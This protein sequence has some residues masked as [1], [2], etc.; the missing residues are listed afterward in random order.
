MANLLKRLAEAMD[1]R[2]IGYMIIG[3]QAVLVYGEPR[4]TRDVDITLATTPEDL[5]S[6]LEIVESLGLRLLVD[7]PKAFV[8]DTWVL[9][10]FDPK[11]GLRVD[12]IFSWTPYERQA[13]ERAKVKRVEGYPI[14]F[15]SPEDVIVLKLL[16][17]RPRD[18]E[19]VKGIL[20][21]VR[22]DYDYILRWLREFAEATGED[23]PATFR[24]IYN[25][26]EN[27]TGDA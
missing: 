14:K 24:R 25:Q 17:G 6:I 12:F 27:E 15:A 8:K 22:V 5:K 11:S 23:L 13:I 20:R 2:G 16:A 7:D 3:G 9:P 1:E 26:V 19:D 21:R 10:T 4:F 18:I